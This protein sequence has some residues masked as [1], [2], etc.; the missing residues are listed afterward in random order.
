MVKLAHCTSVARGSPVRIPG[1][2]ISTACGAML[3][4]ASH[5]LKESRGRWARMLAQ[6]QSSSAK[7]GGWW[8]MLAQGLIFLENKKELQLQPYIEYLLWIRFFA[9]DF[10]S[11]N[12]LLTQ[13]NKS[14]EMR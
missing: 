7:R 9:E 3:W 10:T 8:Q 2:N 11:I 4:Q 13:A 6:G 5:I 14:H 1:V 12:Y